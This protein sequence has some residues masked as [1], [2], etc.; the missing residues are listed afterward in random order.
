MPCR[1]PDIDL[2]KLDEVQKELDETTA[3]LCRLMRWYDNHTTR[4]DIFTEPDLVD[5]W[6]KHEK[7]DLER[8]KTILAEAN[9]HR[10]DL[11]EAREVILAYLD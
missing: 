8:A 3:L 4:L 11:H 6:E 2:M 9:F 1:G 7:L 5:W 10:A